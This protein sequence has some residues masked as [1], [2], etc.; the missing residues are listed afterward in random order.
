[1]AIFTS[2][3]FTRLPDSVAR[4]GISRGVPRGQ[5]GY[6]VMRELA[7]GPW[8]NSVS[9]EEYFRRYAEQLAALDPPAIVARI[10]ARMTP[11]AGGQDA[12]LLCFE[13]PNDPTKHC[14]RAYV[15]AWLH[16]ELG[17]VVREWSD[18]HASFGWG[19]CKMPRLNPPELLRSPSWRRQGP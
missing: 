6:S 19:H 11:L 4:I 14:H 2:S 18:P 1:M 17:L 13:P 8:F 7:P 5:V 15:S 10:V 16:D 3:W 9:A 12:A